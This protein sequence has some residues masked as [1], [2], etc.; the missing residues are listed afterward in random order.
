MA[1][2]NATSRWSAPLPDLTGRLA[3]VTGASDGVGLEIAR[4]LA[5][6]GAELVLP[7]RNRMKGEAAVARIRE[8]TPHARIGLRD[9]DL[10]S[11]Q[12]TGDLV[13]TLAREGRP[14]DLYVANAGII[15]LGDAVRHLSA[16]GCELHFQTN[17]L[18]HAALTAGILPLLRAG[19]AR[20]AVQC[21]LAADHYALDFDD[22]QVERR[23]TALRAYASSKIAL[24]LFG[25]E[26]HRR[27]ARAG[28]G[29]R[30]ALCHPGIALTNI[31]PAELRERDRVW[32]RASRALI[33][34]GPFG[35]S[36]ADA[37]LPALHAVASPDA[38]GGA[39][40]GPSGL[41]HLSGPPRQQRLYRHLADPAA[42]E[43]VWAMLCEML[44]VPFADL[45][46]VRPR[47]R[48]D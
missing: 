26:L 2:P 9:L 18:G 17:F 37:A 39:L 19:N 32:T 4:A 23:Y 5:G 14:I 12:S 30:V 15:L 11:L 38:V 40:Y 33:E 13:Q 45:A 47:T 34:R 3:L 42:A 25:T 43:G 7:V 24:G 35:Q 36:P 8:N 27:S 41:L 10:A 31:A 46:D 1:S 6:A 48:G 16:D 28:W 44:P 20:V 22:V 21:S 29:V